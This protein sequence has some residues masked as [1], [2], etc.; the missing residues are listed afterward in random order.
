MRNRSRSLGVSVRALA[1]TVVLVAAAASLTAGSR[2]LADHVLQK[3]RTIYASVTDKAGVPATLTAAEVTIREDGQPR[4]VVSVKPSSTPMSLTL[5]IDN[6]QATQSMTQELRIGMTG[7]VTS[8]LKQSPDTTISI[9]TFGDRPTP[10]R[11][12]TSSVPVLTKDTGRIF[13]VTGSGAYLLDAIMDATKAFKKINAPRKVIVAFTDESGTEFSNAVHQQ[14]FDAVQASG[15]SV[16]IVVLQGVGTASE[17][18]E[19]RERSAVIGDLP[20]QSGGVTLTIL[21]KQGLSDKMTSLANLLAP[22]FEIS[23]GRPDQ[24]IPPSKLDVTIALKNVNVAAPR[25]TDK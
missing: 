2:A 3:T 8:L 15:A 10:V 22:E 5:L 21:N 1:S 17:S 6:S 19:G 7:F 18:P 23:Y 13:P 9:A 20:R 12:F 25:R 11:D 4:E 16:W 24:L 14:V